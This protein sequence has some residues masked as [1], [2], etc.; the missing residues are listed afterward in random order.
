[1][2]ATECDYTVARFYIG[3]CKM[4]IPID[5]QLD[6]ANLMH[7]E[8]ECVIM[9]NTS[10]FAESPRMVY[11]Y[12]LGGGTDFSWVR[13]NRIKAW[14]MDWLE[15]YQNEKTEHESSIHKE[16]YFWTVAEYLAVIGINL[17][18]II[19][20]ALEMSKAEVS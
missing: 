12:K 17:L 16:K 2:E 6:F 3:W 10:V 1:M 11:S 19:K 7:P 8:L 18:N 9:E 4:N 15:Q 20:L 14:A 13:L 5:K